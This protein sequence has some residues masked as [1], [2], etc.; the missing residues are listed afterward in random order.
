LDI[1]TIQTQAFI[2]LLVP[3]V[4][5][6]AKNSQSKAFA[7]IDQY[8]P[9]ICVITSAVAALATSM[10]IVVVRA[11]HS[12]TISWP[13]SATLAHGL[14]TFVIMTATQFGGQHVFYESLWRHVL[15]SVPLPA[16]RQATL[17]ANPSATLAAGGPGGAT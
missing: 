1:Q 3:F 12:L 10:E 16:V 14:V 5:Q 8:K 6:L 2:T 13:D 4:I 17:A 11:P 15:P 7:W 9:N